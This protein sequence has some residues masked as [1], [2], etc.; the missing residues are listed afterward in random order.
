VFLTSWVDKSSALSMYTTGHT[1]M[2]SIPH[3]K[4]GCWYIDC[5]KIHCPVEEEDVKKTYE[6]VDSKG[7]AVGFDHSE[8]QEEEVEVD[9]NLLPEKE[10]NKAKDKAEKEATKAKD[11]AAKQPKKGGRASR[12]KIVAAPSPPILMTKT[13]TA[14][15]S[16]NPRKRDSSF[17]QLSVSRLQRLYHRPSWTLQ[18]AVCMFRSSSSLALY[19]PLMLIM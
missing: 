12:S 13:S 5:G 14:S 4:A 18:G 16:Q 2:W 17:A 7:A 8:E 10:K 3:L 15:P 6:K 19:C 1:H 9:I 11:K